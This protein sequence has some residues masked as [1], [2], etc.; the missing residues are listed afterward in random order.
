MAESILYYRG[1]ASNVSL[2]DGSR[3]GQDGNHFTSTPSYGVWYQWSSTFTVL[4]QASSMTQTNNTVKSGYVCIY[5]Y[6]LRASSVSLIDGS[7]IAQDG[8]SLS[9]S[10]GNNLTSSPSHGVL[11]EL[12]SRSV[13]PRR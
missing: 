8:N 10:D 9:S 6:W 3:I 13:R 1:G 11:Y 2:I 5:Y 4:L 12:A 7:R